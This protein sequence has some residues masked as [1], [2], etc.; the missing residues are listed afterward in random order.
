ML[1]KQTD[2]QAP[3]QAVP[4]C[5]GTNRQQVPSWLHTDPCRD[6]RGK[7]GQIATEKLKEIVQLCAEKRDK[8]SKTAFPEN[9]K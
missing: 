4:R 1:F 9:N 6:L 8:F 2:L 3:G 7:Q 5:E